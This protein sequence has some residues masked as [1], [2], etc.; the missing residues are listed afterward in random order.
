[1]APQKSRFMFIA[2]LVGCGQEY[3]V[4]ARSEIEPPGD[5]GGPRA[6]LE[7]NGS[8]FADWCPEED[9]LPTSASQNDDRGG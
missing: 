1:M 6:P 3:G 7:F 9:A 2:M 8:A 5:T 4:K